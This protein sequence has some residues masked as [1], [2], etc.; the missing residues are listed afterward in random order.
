VV[1]ATNES[2]VLSGDG[3]VDDGSP[4]FAPSGA[5]LAF[6]RKTL[7]DDQWTPGRQLWLMRPDGS[8]AYALTDDPLYNHSAFRWSP[9]SRTLAY[10][11]FNVADPGLPAEIWTVDMSDSQPSRLVEGFLPEWLP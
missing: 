10:M 7:T 4:S 5:W 8:E 11:R 3:L 1:V 2:V 6:G 9:D